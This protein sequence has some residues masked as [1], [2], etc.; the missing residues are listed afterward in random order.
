MLIKAWDKLPEE[1]QLD[2]VRPYWVILRKKNFSLFWKRVFDIVASSIMLIILSPIF[3]ILAIA[4]K[5]DSK[6][7]VFYRQTRVTQ[8]GREFQIHKF[9]SMCDGA[10][11]KGT[12]VTVKEDARI[13]KV[14]K[15]IRKYRLD[16][17]AQLIDIFQGS[18]SYVGTR[19]EVPK[20]V[21]AYT[22]EMM[23]TLLL[24]AGV[25]SE[26]SIKYKDEDELL[27]TTKDIDETYVQTVLPEKMHYN[28]NSL[29]NYNFFR[30]IG[31]MFRTVF[32]VLR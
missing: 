9:R 6:G 4:I 23:A 7:P 17:V 5:V 30:E 18:M 15:I 27:N 8:Y 19:P 25:T 10:D 20:Y 14:G 12:L 26:A 1:M 31:I 24:P 29:K 11:R 28:L 3:L 13:T 16:E 32:A 2:E 21:K 22:P